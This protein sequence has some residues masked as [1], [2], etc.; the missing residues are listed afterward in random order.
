MGINKDDLI[1]EVFEL[2][3]FKELKAK[4][5]NENFETAIVETLEAAFRNNSVA[6]EEEASVNTESSS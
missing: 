5:P 1:K 4:F 2:E 3:L 6:T